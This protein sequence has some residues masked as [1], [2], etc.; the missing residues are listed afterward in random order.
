MKFISIVGAREHNLKNIDV[1]IPRRSFTVVTGVSGSGKSSLVFDILFAEAQRRFMESL[2]SYARQFVEKLDKPD[3]DFI[4]GLSPSV[5]VDQKTFHRNPRSTVG[6]I[7]E[8]Y[9][10]MRVLFSVVGEPHCYEC[11]EEISSQTPSSMIE[12]IC[13]EAGRKP[14]SVY[15]PVVQGRKGIYRKELEDMRREGFLRVRIDGETYDLEDDIELSRNKKH[16]IELLVDNIV[17]R[18]ERSQKRLT[19]AV[20]LRS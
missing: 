5:S 19:D 16:T 1:K 12:K 17:L 18:G 3:V 11:G 15:S 6:T 20:S 2:S 9:D 14:V 13:E 8:I 4:E 7:T 10:Y